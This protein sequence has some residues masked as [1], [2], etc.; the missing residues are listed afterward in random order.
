MSIFIGIALLVKEFSMKKGLVQNL[1]RNKEKIIVLYDWR[2]RN[3]RKGQLEKLSQHLNRNK[4]EEYNMGWNRDYRGDQRGK[5]FRKEVQT[6]SALRSK[7]RSDHEYSHDLWKKLT[8]RREVHTTN[9]WNRLDSSTHSELPRD[10]ERYHPYQHSSRVE[11]R[12]K[13]RDTSFSLEWRK[14]DHYDM[15]QD[16]N[17]NYTSRPENHRGKH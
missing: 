5:D 15:N 13:N 4:A 2:R 7:R 14:K 11:S 3:A 17:M 16:R 1:L 12:G 10:R 6:N 8:E 9:V